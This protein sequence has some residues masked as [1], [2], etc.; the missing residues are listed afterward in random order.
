MSLSEIKSLPIGA[1]IIDDRTGEEL[2]YNGF[3]GR[4]VMGLDERG[5][6]IWLLPER[7]FY[8]E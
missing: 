8:A 2:K 1:K 4:Y 3:D 7:V 5:I 6:T